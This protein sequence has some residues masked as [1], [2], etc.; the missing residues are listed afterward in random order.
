MIN[1]Q[2]AVKQ[3]NMAIDNIF[4]TNLGVKKKEKV[5]VFTDG[6]NSKLKKIAKD[7]EAA[8]RKFTDRIGYVE[9]HPTGGHGVEPPEEVWREAFGEDIYVELKRNKFIKPLLAKK[10]S[11]SQNSKIEKIISAHRKGAVDAVIALSYYSTSHTKFR[12]LLNRLCRVRYASMPLFDREMLEGA[13]MVNY[14]KMFER[15][16]NI[17]RAVNKCEGME[18]ETP[19]G[20]FLT[21][22]K[23]NREAKA[24]TGIITRPSSFSNLPAGEVFL[25]PLEGTASGRLVIEWAPT[26]RLKKPVTLTVVSGMVTEVEGK[27][28]FAGYLKEKLSESR[29][30]GNIAELGIGTNDKAS[31]PDNILESEKIFGTV[32]VALGDNSTFGGKVRTPFHQD[33]VFFNPTVR[34]VYRTGKRKT[35]IKNGRHIRIAP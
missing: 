31:R 34:L 7:I 1:S 28:A 35:L 9:Y 16:T 15:T 33:F 21:F 22:S 3:A 29:D 32:H 20:T 30:N 10:T 11:Q 13:M 12:D 14:K 27:E 26:R 4:R 8:G 2:S 5:L 17:A 24:D 6:H 19:N 25:A 23:K 18:I